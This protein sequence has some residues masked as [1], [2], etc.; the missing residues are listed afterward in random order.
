MGSQASKFEKAQQE[1]W[2][3]IC[4]KRQP[5]AEHSASLPHFQDLYLTGYGANGVCVVPDPQWPAQLQVL[6]VC[7]KSDAILELR[8]LLLEIFCTIRHCT[9]DCSVTSQLLN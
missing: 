5:P 6:A 9:S 2:R 4:S 7:V 1:A 8:A 3:K